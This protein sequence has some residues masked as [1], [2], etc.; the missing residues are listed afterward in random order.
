MYPQMGTICYCAS[1]RVAARKA[2]ARYDAALETVGITVAQFSLLR[3]IERAEPVSLTELGRL[4][5]LDRSTVG[6]N[7]RVLAG[8]GLVR[9]EAAEDQ[10]EAAVSLAAAGAAALLHATPLWEKAQH[11]I[12]TLLGAEGAGALRALANR[13]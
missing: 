6:R 2:T 1:L 3:R 4:A 12:E 5:E 8:L 13:L 7:V 9:L 11:D 10:R